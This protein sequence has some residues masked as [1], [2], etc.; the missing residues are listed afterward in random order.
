MP[1]IV[2][3]L[4]ILAGL[5][6]AMLSWAV[7]PATV[8]RGDRLLLRKQR[9]LHP[10]PPDPASVGAATG[11]V[12]GLGQWVR[13]WL[14]LTPLRA[15]ETRLVQAGYGGP[16]ALDVA[17]VLKLALTG[18][19]VG[20]GLLVDVTW[21][22]AGG[23]AGWLAVDGWLVQA[24]RRRQRAITLA[25]PDGLDMLAVSVEAGLSL[26]AALQRY[27]SNETPSSRALSQE[28]RQFLRDIQLGRSRQEAF[29]DLGRR[30]GVHD[31]HLLAAALKQ[32]DRWGVE[33]ANVMRVQADHLRSRRL[34]RAEEQA[35]KAPVKILLPLVFCIF[36]A[37]FVVLLGPAA[38]QLSKLFP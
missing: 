14:P 15:L 11:W 33:M 23:L 19:G 37:I 34:L 28:I 26:E 7:L 10:D 25:L 1:V 36:P 13:A 38:M 2:A 32:A 20:G 29:T 27:C 4:V 16:Q 35:M 31:L 3:A 9:L 22:L 5:S 21:G 30:S 12:T 24:G 18:L 17:V 6:V 8:T